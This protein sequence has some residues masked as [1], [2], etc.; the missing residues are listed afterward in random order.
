MLDSITTVLF[1]KSDA[2]T[3]E[4]VSSKLALTVLLMCRGDVDSIVSEMFLVDIISVGNMFVVIE[5]VNIDTVSKISV[6][7]DS[8]EKMS[9]V[10][11]NDDISIVGSTG[12]CS[13]MVPFIEIS[14][15]DENTACDSTEI[16][17]CS[18]IKEKFAVVDKIVEI[19]GVE[20]FGDIDE[21]IP[22]VLVVS[23]P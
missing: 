9:D 19:I 5:V 3:T 13:K 4:D 18:G 20:K 10:I 14:D 7:M 11:R 22:M 6:T 2:K 12:V 21:N 16:I 23:F 15:L 8:E 17:D 1:S